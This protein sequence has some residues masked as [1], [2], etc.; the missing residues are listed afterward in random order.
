[1]IALRAFLKYLA[2]NDIETL[3]PEKIELAKTSQ[4]ELDLISRKEFER[5]MEV[6]IKKNPEKLENV[7]DKAI[8]EMLYSTGLRVS[9]L[10]SLNDD[11]DLTADEFSIRGKGDKVRLVFLSDEA[12]K[13]TKKY[14][15][16]RE[17]QGNK[18]LDDALFLTS[19]GNRIH[20]RFV[21][22]MI[23]KRSA[24]AGIMKKVT[25][26][27]IRHFFATDLLQNGADIRSVQMLLGH[28]SINTTQVYTNISDKFL[29]EVHKKFHNKKEN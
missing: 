8:L 4:R 23:Q 3:A 25:P 9:E 19:S 15:E 17:K 24:E 10:C 5:L 18:I 28:A 12:K 26:H 14:L 13:W 29:K 21:Q 22:R 16:L 20:P 7:R 1:M 11:L 2:K 27:T 6:P